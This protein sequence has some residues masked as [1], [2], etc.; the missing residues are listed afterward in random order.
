MI[1]VK[2]IGGHAFNMREDFMKEE[3]PIGRTE[4]AH[5]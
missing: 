3:R 1:R 2:C 4:K 5:T